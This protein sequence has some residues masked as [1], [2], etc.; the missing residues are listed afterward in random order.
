MDDRYLERIDMYLRKEM[1][2][3]ECVAFEQE[4][5]NC[6]EL[7]RELEL[8]HVIACV[9]GK[10]QQ[11]IDKIA[12]WERSRRYMNILR[13][14]TAAV[15]AILVFGFLFVH[16]G[17]IS[18]TEQ[19]LLSETN[20]PA[21]LHANNKNAIQEIKTAIKKGKNVEAIDI[22]NDLENTNAIPTLNE[23]A[24]IRPVPEQSVCSQELDSLNNDAYELHWLKICSLI[25]VGKRQEAVASLKTFITIEGQY[26]E[27][28]DSLLRVLEH[29]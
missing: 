9:L 27:K 11:K 22:I 15:A 1:T 12:Q 8:T 18:I 3:E 6:S 13:I 17:K 29:K 20:T 14:S 26:A 2:A 16:F 7:H 10:R 24:G 21:I 4:V 25:N 19:K 5:L 23:M 28:A